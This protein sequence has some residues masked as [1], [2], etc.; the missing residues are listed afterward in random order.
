MVKPFKFNEF[1]DSLTN[2][3]KED[4][5]DKIK[6]FFELIET[7]KDKF[8]EGFIKFLEWEKE[9]KNYRLKYGVIAA[10][11]HDFLTLIDYFSEA[12]EIV[13]YFY[14]HLNLHKTCSYKD[15]SIYFFFTNKIEIYKEGNGKIY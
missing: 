11:T 6:R 14:A 10:D 15:Y 5:F 13:T 2:N 7:D 4:R 8:D 1:I 3:K 12:G 9:Y